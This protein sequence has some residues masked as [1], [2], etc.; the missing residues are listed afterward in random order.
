MA[1]VSPL[2]QVRGEA[3]KMKCD[4]EQVSG[5]LQEDLGTE[6]KSMDFELSSTSYQLCDLRQVT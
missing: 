2:Q 6:V 4:K 5:K 1:C 3:V